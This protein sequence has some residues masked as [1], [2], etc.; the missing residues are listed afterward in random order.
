MEKSNRKI[1]IACILLA[2]LLT[3]ALYILVANPFDKETDKPESGISSTIETTTTTKNETL[4]IPKYD[5]KAYVELN[6]NRPSFE[7]EDLVTYSYESYSALDSLGRCGEAIACIGKDLMPTEKRGDI[8]SVH[9]SGWQSVRYSIVDGGS[10]YNRCHLIGF[11]LTGENAN[12]QNLITGTR[13]MNT[14]GMLAFEDA[15]ADFVKDTN[16]HVLYRVT[17]IF[18]GKN[19]VADGVQMEGYSVEDNG[20]GICFNVFCY[21]VQP[22]IFIDYSNGDSHLIE[23]TSSDK[24][25]KGTYVLN[26]SSHKFHR[27]E[28]DGALNMNSKNRQEYTGSRQIL[29]DQG[30][31]PCTVC[32][33]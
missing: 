2:V 28:C 15:V 3:V 29:I 4:S 30:Y 10:L 32:N 13:Y 18:T 6:G 17:P 25:K 21:N 23:E 20:E 14:V 9:P 24:S 27:P 26:R 12:K 22:G 5:G 31:K 16:Y 1:Q 8:G 19:L 33:P 11:Q 7:A